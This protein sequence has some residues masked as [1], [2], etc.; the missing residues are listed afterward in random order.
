[1]RARAIA[2]AL[3]LLPA[4]LSGCGGGGGGGGNDSRSQPP[5]LDPKTATAGPPADVRHA[6]ARVAATIRDWANAERNS[7]VD[8]AAGF[9]SLPAIVLNGP[10]PALLRTRQDVREWN[11]ALPCGAALLRA[12]D[13]R[14]WTVARFQLVDRTG[15]HCDAPGGT[16]STAFAMRGGK[17]ALWV[18]VRDDVPP[19]K[20][21][22]A[23][24]PD[25]EFLR[26]GRVPGTPPAPKSGQEGPGPS[27]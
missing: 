5:P 27:V 11:D 23:K 4:L 25:A 1:M 20:A 7:R 14:G 9:F 8:A 18:R 10:D 2:L 17:I 12:V 24:H 13:V 15:G 19:E 16:A 26:T 22:P 3:V 21:A 6:N